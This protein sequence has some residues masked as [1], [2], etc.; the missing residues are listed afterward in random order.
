MNL[1]PQVPVWVPTGLQIK[2]SE[3][4]PAGAWGY[5]DVRGRSGLFGKG[6]LTHFGL[7]DHTF[8]SEIKVGMV[9]LR[10][11]PFLINP[12]D[13]IAQIMFFPPPG[14]HAGVDHPADVI[15]TRSQT[16]FED[17]RGGFGSTGME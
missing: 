16:P 12:G 13:R 1:F 5:A 11:D 9:N 4:S 8:N 6:I 14:Y 2:W 15:L 7:I 10:K 17:N 3:V